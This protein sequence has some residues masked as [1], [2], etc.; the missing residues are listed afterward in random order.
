MQVYG[1]GMTYN[2]CLWCL[3]IFCQLSAR[4]SYLI[5]Y[6]S[7]N[8]SFRMDENFWGKPN[9]RQFTTK[10]H[11]FHSSFQSWNQWMKLSFFIDNPVTCTQRLT[12][13][14]QMSVKCSLVYSIIAANV[15]RASSQAIHHAF[16]PT[17]LLRILKKPYSFQNKLLRNLHFSMVLIY[18]FYE[19]ELN[20]ILFYVS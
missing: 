9:H 10:L 5:F 7:N 1:N 11:S 3:A 12:A 14:S 16:K 15:T 2:C 19:R 6:H 18:P 4:N 8:S 17:T 13:V 20:T